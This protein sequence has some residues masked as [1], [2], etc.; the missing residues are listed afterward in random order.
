MSIVYQVFIFGF[1]L[2]R[3]YSD[4]KEYYDNYCQSQTDERKTQ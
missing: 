4:L 3:K 2:N 1:L